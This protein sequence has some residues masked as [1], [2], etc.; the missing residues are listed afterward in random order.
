MKKPEKAVYGE[1][2]AWYVDVSCPPYNVSTTMTPEDQRKGIQ[3]AW[4]DVS[5]AGGGVVVL[6]EMYT[7]SRKA[8]AFY[9]LLTRDNVAVWGVDPSSSGLR[10]ATDTKGALMLVATGPVNTPGG[11]MNVSLARLT[12]DGNKVDFVPGTGPMPQRHCLWLQEAVNVLCDQVWFVNPLMDGAYHHNNTHDTT[13][14]DCLFTGSGRNGI[15]FTRAAHNVKISRCRFRDIAVQ[16]IDSEPAAG[17]VPFDILV[18]GCT[19]EQSS[20]P[21][22]FVISV[23]G[24][25]V[26]DADLTHNWRFIGNRFEGSVNVTYARNL[27]FSGNEWVILDEAYERSCLSL[28]HINEHVVIVGNTFESTVNCIELVG[29]ANN[30]EAPFPQQP[31]DITMDGNT[32]HLRPRIA[33]PAS[34]TVVSASGPDEYMFSNNTVLDATDGTDVALSHRATHPNKSVCICGNIVRQCSVGFRLISAGTD[35]FERVIVEGNTFDPGSLPASF[36]LV[37]D[38]NDIIRD[39]NDPEPDPKKKR[40]LKVIED[41]VLAGN[42]WTGMG[43]VPVACIEQD[44]NKNDIFVPYKGNQLWR[45]DGNVGTQATYSCTGSP[46]GQF[47]APVGSLAVRR[48]GSPGAT[49]YVK[50]ADTPTGWSAR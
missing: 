45:T 7:V 23:A 46:V 44:A 43:I 2:D 34:R 9:C 4:D 17:V 8:G 39:P 42:I 36:A 24:S 35:R 28:N 49:F 47:D 19:F 18:E 14:R 38:R 1:S 5:A 13:F 50:E 40:L 20:G 6:P 31:R 27:V 30:L 11:A 33:Q 32:F 15:S 22:E 3:Q 29:V 41:F 10:M 48:D 16:Q 12:L 26:A 21:R 37:L 25:G